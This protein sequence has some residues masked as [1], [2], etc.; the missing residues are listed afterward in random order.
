MN[1]LQNIKRVFGGNRIISH[2]ID[3]SLASTTSEIRKER[4]DLFMHELPEILDSLKNFISQLNKIIEEQKSVLN[5]QTTSIRQIA[6]TS[7]EVSASARTISKNTDELEQYAHKSISA[8]ER[9]KK[10]L[11]DTMEDM[12]ATSARVHHLVKNIREIEANNRLISEIAE[13]IHEITSQLNLLAL[14]AQIE[15]AAAGPYGRRFAIVAQEVKRLSNISKESSLRIQDTVNIILDNVSHLVNSA[16]ECLKATASSLENMT[17]ANTDIQKIH[18]EISQTY[19]LTREIKIS[20]HQQSIAQQELAHSLTE[21]DS[22]TY[23]NIQNISSQIEN[24]VNNL[25]D[26]AQYFS[27]LLETSTKFPV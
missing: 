26:L 20:T 11:E 14:N 15:A 23:Q 6:V 17:K 24:A 8:C 10:A 19:S 9:G 7:E 22:A 12:K 16:Q 27:I 4:E 5:Y 2:E 25:S 13:I 1:W 18:E 3:I 21:V